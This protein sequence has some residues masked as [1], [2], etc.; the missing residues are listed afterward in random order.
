MGTTVSHGEHV[1]KSKFRL[2]F[3]ARDGGA[4]CRI[5]LTFDVFSLE[6]R[7]WMLNGLDTSF[8]PTDYL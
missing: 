3:A 8:E 2:N 6:D 1:F 4:D 5:L 7:N